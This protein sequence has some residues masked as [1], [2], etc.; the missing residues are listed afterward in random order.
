MVKENQ[1]FKAKIEWRK[2]EI[3]GDGMKF[4][5]HYW[6]SEFILVNVQLH[7][8]RQ[9]HLDRQPTRSRGINLNSWPCLRNTLPADC[10]GFMPIPSFV[11]MALVAGGTLNS[12]A[13]NFKTAVK[14]VASG[15]LSTLK[16]S[17]GSEVRVT[18]NVTLLDILV[19]FNFRW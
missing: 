1:R 19:G 18:L 11:M 5:F 15:T 8:V 14:G 10:W 17:L 16:G 4:F 6:N 7:L 12:S 13:A 2:T 9:L 3:W